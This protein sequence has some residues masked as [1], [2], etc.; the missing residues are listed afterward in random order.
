MLALLWRICVRICA[1]IGV[2]FLL[3]TFT[4]FVAWYGQ[5]LAGPWNDPEGDTLVV[6]AGGSLDEN[7][8]AESTLVRCLYAL[9][10]YRGGHFRKVVVAGLGAGSQIRDLLACQGVP[11]EAL[12]VESASRSTRENAVNTAR[13]LAGDTGST[14]LLTSDYH[15]FRAA[16]AFRKA[17]LRVLPR[18]IPDAGKRAATRLRRWP[19]FLDEMVETVKILYYTARRWI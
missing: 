4:P 6:L 8:P 7:F 9:R 16:R 15:M 10:A 1:V 18:P 19:A 2:I 17:G 11:A 14:V 5:K 13:L 12:V 3:V